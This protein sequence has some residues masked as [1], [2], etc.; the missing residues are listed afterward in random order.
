M[1]FFHFIYVAIPISA[2][3][4]H[5]TV[6]PPE[7]SYVANK[8]VLTLPSEEHLNGDK[9]CAAAY[10]TWYQE[11]KVMRERKAQLL[12]LYPDDKRYKFSKI[13]ATPY[14]KY[15][16]EAMPLIDVPVEA[17]LGEP[18][19][20]MPLAEWRGD[21]WGCWLTC[22]D[23]RKTLEWILDAKLNSDRKFVR[24]KYP[25]G[26][27][28]PEGMISRPK[29]RMSWRESETED[30]VAAALSV[31]HALHPRLQLGHLNN[32]QLITEGQTG[33]ITGCECFV[34]TKWEKAYAEK[35]LTVNYYKGFYNSVN[36]ARHKRPAPDGDMPSKARAKCT[37]PA[38]VEPAQSSQTSAAKVPPKARLKR[39]R[40]ATVEPAQSS[41]TS[42]ASSV[43]AE[44]DD[45]AD[46][47]DL[48][49]PQ[50]AILP[51][52]IIFADVNVEDIDFLRPAEQVVCHD[53]EYPNLELY[54]QLQIA[55]RPLFEAEPDVLQARLMEFAN[56]DFWSWYEPGHHHGSG[57]TFEHG[58]SSKSPGKN[59]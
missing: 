3:P 6:Y 58:S 54:D 42:A 38:T 52:E 20:P 22:Q 37:R 34:P 18:F 4:L 40:P 33:M 8:I 47:P 11:E 59:P 12:L 17:I 49:P 46:Q 35:M 24:A 7:F 48:L 57:S 31:L 16:N 1:L 19:G 13:F 21:F 15:P 55:P 14:T 28:C 32:L 29:T 2:I 51:G 27:L 9:V 44:R 39:P 50:D 10:R 5:I 41:Q 45:E 25:F 53:Y 30:E 26:Y 43:L 36:K 56:M 23:I